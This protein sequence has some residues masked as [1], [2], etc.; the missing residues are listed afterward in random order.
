MDRRRFLMAMGAGLLGGCEFT[1]ADGVWNACAARAPDDAATR[2]LVHSAWR[3]LDPSRVWDVHC[4]V[5]GNGDSGSGL[6]FNP[7]LERIWPV[8]GY[9]QR[10]FYLNAS[11]VH[12][13]PGQVDRSVVDRLLNQCDEMPAGFRAMLFAFDWSRDDAGRPDRERSTFHVPDAYCAALAAQHPARFEWVAS[14]HP[15]DPAALDRLDAAAAGGARAVKWIPAA[16][17]IDPAS[18]RCDRFYARLAKLGLPLVCHAGDEHAMRTVSESLGNPLRLRRPLDAGVRVVVAH[19]ASL[20][21]GDDLD[22]PGAPARTN[23]E[24]FA[25]LM[26]DPRYGKLVAGDLSAL[27]QGHRAGVIETLLARRD[28]HPRLLNG[29]DYPIPGVL[30][31][32]SLPYLVRLGLLDAGAAAT[33]RPLRDRNVLLFDFVLKRRLVN[34]G[35]GFPPSVFE[36]RPFFESPA[37]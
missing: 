32:V 8:T 6:S 36:T 28:W 37:S 14:I 30:P 9:V 3:G 15:Y 4:H 11:C 5:F 7:A 31:L 12:D 33:L 22:R 17:G 18:S 29:S 35:V 19:C 26:D 20:G 13:A 16:H 25:R 34:N 10:L 1:L 21:M 27:A 23:F 2:D 24:L